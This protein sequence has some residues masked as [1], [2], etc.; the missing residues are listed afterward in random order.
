MGGGGGGGWRREVEGVMALLYL[1]NSIR[2]G[3]D[4]IAYNW[5]VEWGRSGGRGE[6]AS[7]VAYRGW[8]DVKQILRRVEGRE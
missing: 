6:G 1:G 8:R 5:G 4:Q 3:K 7:L 2:R